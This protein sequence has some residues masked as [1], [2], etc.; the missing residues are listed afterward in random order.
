MAQI[1]LEL[2]KAEDEALIL[3]LLKR[4]EIPYSVV[5]KKMMDEPIRN[6]HKAIIQQGAHQTDFDGFLADFNQ[7]RQDRSLPFPE[8]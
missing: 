4:L 1:T 2:E 3:S 6:H 5:T 8:K 7:S